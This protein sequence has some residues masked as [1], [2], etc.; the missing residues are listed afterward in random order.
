[1]VA[2]EQLC[3]NTIEKS[4]QKIT[5][6]ENTNNHFKKQ[7]P[8]QTNKKEKKRRHCQI[9]AFKRNPKSRDLHE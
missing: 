6:W 2:A 7:T 1:M 9:I 3:A 8:E 5:F 4:P